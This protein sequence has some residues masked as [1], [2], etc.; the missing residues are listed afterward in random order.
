M[1]RV[2]VGQV[3]DGFEVDV[4]AGEQA[5]ELFDQQGPAPRPGHAPPVQ[6]GLVQVDVGDHPGA[7]AGRSRRSRLVGGGEEVDD[8]FGVGEPAEG[9]GAQVVAGR[10]GGEVRCRV[11]VAVQG[12][13]DLVDH[14]VEELCWS[15]L[16]A[17][18]DGA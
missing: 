8:A 18:D 2:L 14:G 15:G 7:P 4:G 11:A 5:L 3:D 10:V 6:G 16:D 13:G 17:G 9:L 1:T 12:V